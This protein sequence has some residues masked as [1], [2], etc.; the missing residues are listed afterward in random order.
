MQGKG[1]P[2]PSGA[3]AVEYLAVT[4]ESGGKPYI[5]TEYKTSYRDDEMYFKYMPI[6]YKS[7]GDNLALIEE[8]VSYNINSTANRIFWIYSEK[9]LL[10]DWHNYGSGST[11]SDTVWLS[12]NIGEINT[13]EI[14]ER[15]YTFNGIKGNLKALNTMT[16]RGNLRIFNSRYVGNENIYGRVYAF[17]IRKEGEAVLDL[18]PVR[19]GDEGFMY[20]RVSGRLFGNS[21]TGRFVVGP[22]VIL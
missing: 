13:L 3:V 11:A 10:L 6:Q 15:E 14:K 4:E 20:D 8:N 16:G 18:V 5:D 1:A 21:G 22:D 7:S 19:V 2:L 9:K 17:S 12:D